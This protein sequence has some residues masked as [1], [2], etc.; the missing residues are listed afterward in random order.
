MRAPQKSLSIRLLRVHVLLP[1]CLS[2]REV[3]LSFRCAPV[4]LPVHPHHT[5]PARI[6][7]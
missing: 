3:C 5:E 7:S 1:L 6:K 4:P 2:E